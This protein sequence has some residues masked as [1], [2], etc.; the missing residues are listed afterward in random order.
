M[1]LSICIPTTNGR[2][3]VLDGTLKSILE[4]NVGSEHNVLEVVVS[5]NSNSDDVFNVVHYYMTQG[6]NINYHKSDEKTFYNLIQALKLAKGDFIK[7]HNDYSDFNK[8]EL[9]SLIKFIDAHKENKEQILFTNGNLAFKGIRHFPTFNDFI[10]GSSYWNTWA[11]GFSMWRDDFEKMDLSKD[12]LDENF[13]H[14]SLLFS[15]TNKTGFI[16]N[17]NYIFAGQT[18]K[19]KGGYNIFKL[20]CIDYP[21]MLINLVNSGLITQKTYRSILVDMRNYF[22]PMWLSVSVYSRNG[23]TFDNDS[24][25][26]SLRNIYGGFDLFLIK[27]NAYMR[28][29]FRW[30]KGIMPSVSLRCTSR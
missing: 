26:E 25:D 16:I 10:R 19:G 28:S 4:S 2:A 23:F 3:D 18:V 20:F 5:D 8:G 9:L 24:Y 15:N 22:I 27:S 13:P 11:S 21:D 1:L 30:L 7:L 17:N 29:F 12:K 6:L 14:V